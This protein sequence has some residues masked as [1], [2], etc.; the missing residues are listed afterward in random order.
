MPRKGCIPFKEKDHDFHRENVLTQLALDVSYR[1]TY[2]QEY[3]CNACH[4]R[5]RKTTLNDSS[6]EATYLSFTY[7]CASFHQDVTRKSCILFR[8]NFESENI[9]SQL[10]SDVRYKRLTW[11]SIFVMHVTKD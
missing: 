10:H 9:H 8:E 7:T 6:N 1:R 2:M 3:I 4:R 5:L 11:K